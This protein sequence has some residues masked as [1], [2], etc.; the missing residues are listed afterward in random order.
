MNRQ[1]PYGQFIKDTNYMVKNM[2]F[3]FHTTYQISQCLS[4][5]SVSGNPEFDCKKKNSQLRACSASLA[6]NNAEMFPFR[7]GNTYA[8]STAGQQFWPWVTTQ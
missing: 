2:H 1:G 8:L 3:L 6:I 7:V 4:R 5:N